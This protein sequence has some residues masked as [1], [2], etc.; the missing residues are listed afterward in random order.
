MMSPLEL[1]LVPNGLVW[2]GVT[3]Y[4]DV[5]PEGVTHVYMLR[6]YGDGTR[7]FSD[8]IATSSP[9]ERLQTHTE[10]DGWETVGVTFDSPGYYK[11]GKGYMDYDGSMS[12]DPVNPKGYLVDFQA[13]AAT[14]SHQLDAS[15]G[16]HSLQSAEESDRLTIF[17]ALRYML[18][19]A[20]RRYGE[21]LLVDP[22]DLIVGGQYDGTLLWRR[23]LE[24]YIGIDTSICGQCNISTFSR[25]ALVNANIPLLREHDKQGTVYTF[26][27]STTPWGLTEFDYAPSPADGWYDQQ[28]AQYESALT[29]YDEE[30][31]SA[32]HP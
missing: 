24:D 22:E 30:L 8:P 9:M 19:S 18:G 31:G 1:P 3:E 10:R 32:L 28:I 17:N 6:M 4:Q 29:Y 27:R 26:D 23:N 21:W 12:F 11:E 5:L 2:D 13:H 14:F 20:W 7:R 16:H 15:M 25:R